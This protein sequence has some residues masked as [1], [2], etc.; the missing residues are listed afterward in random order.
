MKIQ[1][2]PAL[3]LVILISL[4]SCAKK[5]NTIYSNKRYPVGNVIFL[6]KAEIVGKA[7]IPNRQQKPNHTKQHNINNKSKYD[8][9]I[10]NKQ[11]TTNIEPLKEQKYE[12]YIQP[13]P[14]E[15]NEVKKTI[16][17]AQDKVAQ[18][19]KIMPN[20]KA[21]IHKKKSNKSTG[22]KS[23]KKLNT[24]KGNTNITIEPQKL[25]PLNNNINNNIHTQI[26]TPKPVPEKL[27]PMQPEILINNNKNTYNLP[28]K[29][30]LKNI[31]P[32]QEPS[33]LDDNTIAPSRYNRSYNRA[34]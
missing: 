20:N 24:L 1:H 22:Q 16:T 26:I 19:K 33:K 15:P 8:L 28:E 34:F 27:S 9:R 12:K 11:P 31:N 23:E 10:D 30:V 13:K 32:A 5:Q 25:Q 7:N 17:P 2:L 4:T 14:I 3:L 18:D 21:P 6:N 29:N